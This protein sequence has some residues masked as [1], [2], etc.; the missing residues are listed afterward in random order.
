[1]DEGGEEP[2][3]VIY[4]ATGGLDRPLPSRIALQASGSI[5]DLLH[6]VHVSASD[7]DDA[8]AWQVG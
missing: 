2:R 1:M 5:L 4:G 7:S 6:N 3:D 8:T